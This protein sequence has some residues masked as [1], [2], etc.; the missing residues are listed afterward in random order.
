MGAI[1]RR[2]FLIRSGLAS[3]RQYWLPMFPFP[4][5]LLTHRRT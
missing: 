3:A 1:D 4:G 5:P 2:D